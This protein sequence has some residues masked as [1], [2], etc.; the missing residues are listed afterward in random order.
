VLSTI[1]L[2]AAVGS[3]VTGDSMMGLGVTTDLRCEVWSVAGSKV[4]EPD[5]RRPLSEDESSDSEMEPER[6]AEGLMRPIEERRTAAPKRERREPLP[7]DVDVS[8]AIVVVDV[9]RLI[10]TSYTPKRDK[11]WEHGVSVGVRCGLDGKKIVGRAIINKS[12]ELS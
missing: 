12:C 5:L 2:S 3:L 7:G 1:A 8:V 9:E 11:G 10:D 4:L 6:E